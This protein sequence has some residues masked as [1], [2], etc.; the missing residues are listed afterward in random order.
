MCFCYRKIKGS[1]RECIDQGRG[2]TMLVDEAYQLAFA[3]IFWPRG[4]RGNH[5]DD[6]WISR[7]NGNVVGQ[8]RRSDEESYLFLNLP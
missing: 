2:A 8:K 6:C 7:R 1:T 4:N 5:G 3:E